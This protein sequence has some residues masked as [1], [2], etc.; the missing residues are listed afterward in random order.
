MEALEAIQ[1]RNSSPRLTGA[2]SS[3]QVEDLLTAGLRAPDHAQ[4]RPW[5][6]IVVEGKSRDRLGA[7]FAQAKL[8]R[9]PNQPRDQLEKL[10]SK[11]LRAPLVLVV[12]ATPK[13]HP[14]VPEIEQILSAGAVAQN[15]LNAAH[16]LGL[17]AMWR[18][19]EMA[20]DPV[21]LDGLGLAETGKIV[22]FIYVGEIDG[23]QK[24]IPKLNVSDYVKHW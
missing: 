22:A 11:P 3:D 20:Y 10:K 9:D 12:A 4:L 16:A 13:D 7:L 2:V 21:V 19:G 18:T 6:I 8:T 23:R 15:I 5:Q 1:K 17:G 24:S 14:K